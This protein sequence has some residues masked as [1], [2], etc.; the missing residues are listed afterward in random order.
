MAVR[1]QKTAPATARSKG[2]GRGVW[3]GVALLAAV[4]I[5]ATVWLLWP[6]PYP[7]DLGQPVDATR[8]VGVAEAL[9]VAD[10]SHS[11]SIVVRGRISE[12]CRSAGCWFVLQEV[13]GGRL[14]EV[15]VDLKR[16]ADFTVRPEVLGRTAIVTGSRVVDGANTVVE[17]VG[18]HIE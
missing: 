3:I 18:A 2:A 10:P 8:A 5:A 14:Y 17:A 9:Q 1:E 16:R 6:R 11:E 7:I 15:L 12:V 4:A 13:S